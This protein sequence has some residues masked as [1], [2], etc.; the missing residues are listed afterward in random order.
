MVPLGVGHKCVKETSLFDY[1][2]PKN[3]FVLTNLE[4]M[5]EDRELWGDPENF[6][7]ERF[8]NNDEL[9]KDLSF[10]FGLGMWIIPFNS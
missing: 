2:I 4:A 8:L 3:T 6:R 1:T 7:P 9:S 10:N 5:N